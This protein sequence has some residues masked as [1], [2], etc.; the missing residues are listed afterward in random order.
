MS[1]WEKIMST[2]QVKLIL[3][4][5]TIQRIRRRIEGRLKRNP[6]LVIAVARFL[7]MEIN[8]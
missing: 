6:E 8:K 2:G 7:K 3:T 1:L 4:D 5:K